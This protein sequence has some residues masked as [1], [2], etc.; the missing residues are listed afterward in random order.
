MKEV[1]RVFSIIFV[2]WSFL[3]FISA[4][5]LV[6]PFILACS[7][8]LP[9]RKAGDFIFF[10]LDIWAIIFC[11]LCFFRISTKNRKVIQPA[12]AYIYVCNHSSYLDAVAVVRAIPGSF[13]PLGK[14]EMAA[15]P[16]FG[17]IYRR[18]VIM[19][20]RASKES[21]AKSVEQLKAELAGGQSI[22]LFPEGTMNRTDKPLTEFYDGAFRL[23]IEIQAPILPLV[24][25]NARNLLPRANPWSA[26]PGQITCVFDEPIEVSH[27][28]IEDLGNLKSQVY[29][30]MQQLIEA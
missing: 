1:K 23:A 17:I 29:N 11:S 2:L 26:R 8:F 30:R 5:L 4:M 19:I 14:I 15:V 22:L 27:M 9:G 20:D 24:I 10:F 28:K 6:L 25:C 3:I 12:R 16:I 7:P 18:V 13:K 21:R